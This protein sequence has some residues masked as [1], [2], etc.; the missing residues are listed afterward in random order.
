MKNIPSN[1][2]LRSLGMYSCGL[3]KAWITNVNRIDGSTI[4]NGCLSQFPLTPWGFKAFV[5]KDNYVAPSPFITKFIPGHDWRIL[6]TITTGE[7]VHVAFQFSD[8]MDCDSI[9]NSISINSSALGNQTAQLD[10]STVTCSTIPEMD[11][12][13]WVGAMTSVYNYS[14]VLENVFHGVHELVVNNVSNKN[15]DRSTGVSR[16]LFPGGV[17]D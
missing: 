10:K 13:T 5:P 7:R 2:V 14:V 15:G 1:R 4:P 8:E 3:T 11:T 9:T 16:T 12:A 17:I 6:S